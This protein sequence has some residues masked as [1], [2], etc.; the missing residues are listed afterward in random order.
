[1]IGDFFLF[2]VSIIAVIAFVFG[3]IFIAVTLDK[4]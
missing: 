3:L 2:I 4:D 1:M